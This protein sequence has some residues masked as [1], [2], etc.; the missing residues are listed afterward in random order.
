[1]YPSN[2]EKA[3]FVKTAL[4]TKFFSPN[5]LHQAQTTRNI[6]VADSRFTV[7][8]AQTQEE[9][10]T[11]LRLRYQVFKVE[12]GREPED[13]SGIEEDGFDSTSHHLIAIENESQKIIGTYRLRTV[14][15]M[16]EGKGFY[17]AQEFD[18]AQ[19]PLE[20]LNQSVEI[21][22]AC[23]DAGFRNS[24]VLFL[25]W[26]GLAAYMLEMKK[27]YFFG[28]CSIFSQNEEDGKKAFFQ[29]KRDGYF[30]ENLHV[31][32]WINNLNLEDST[33]E[34]SIKTVELPKLFISYLRIGAKVCSPPL[35]DREFGTIDF[36]VIFDFE[37]IEERYFKMFF[38]PSK[39]AE[40]CPA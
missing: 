29:L 33:T 9:L 5:F 26:R 6:K 39:N 3:N 32:P 20:V 2:F 24:K 18:L 22:R 38:A 10:S 4:P 35:I 30:H 25:L 15:L 37:K 17:S 23:I 40:L 27:R 28:C 7:K 21:G 11:V 36:F 13:V 12:I 8:I 34:N 19:L 14:E 16:R 1:M 31:S